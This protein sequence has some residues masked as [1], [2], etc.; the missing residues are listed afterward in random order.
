V[1]SAALSGVQTEAGPAYLTPASILWDVPT[2]YGDANNTV[3]RNFDGTYRGP[4]SVRGALQNSYN[5]PAVKTM[6][7]TGTEAFIQTAQAMGLRF[8]PEAEV[9]L[10]SA[11]GST[12]VRLYDMMEAYGTISNDGTLAPLYAIE[13]ITDGAGNVINWERTPPSRAI[14]EPT[15]FLL[16]NIMSDD[17]ARIPAFGANNR[18]AF[19]NFPGQVAAKTGTSNDGIDLWTMGFTDNVVVGVWLGHVDNN[20]TFNTSGYLTASPLWRTIMEN[21]LANTTAPTPWDTPANVVQTQFCATTGTQ[22]DPT[23][24]IPCNDVRTGF[25]TAGQLPPPANE[26]YI[27]DQSVYTWTGQAASSFC[28]NDVE[29]FRVLAP[30]DPTATAWLTGNQSGQQFVQSLG[31]QNAIVGNVESACDANTQLLSAGITGPQGGSVVTSPQVQIQG[32]ISS[33]PNFQ[34]YDIQVASANAPDQFQIVDGP[35]T[36]LPTGPTLGT[37]DAS[38]AADGAY[39]IRVGINSSAGAPFGYAYRTVEFTLDKPE[40][41]PTPTPP[42]IPTAPPIGGVPGGGTATDGTTPPTPTLIP[43]DSGGTTFGGQAGPTPTI[44]FSG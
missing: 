11:L 38:N 24:A 13:E 5:V 29:S 33:A 15:A 27:R 7:F 14:S 36:T 8:L 28:P 17:Q 34:S 41:T 6:N 19:N 25:F 10:T 12:D 31:L 37:W 22:V 26:G 20:P 4:V 39:I 1:Y 16:Q 9:N 21:V 30:D 23:G 43:F 35:Y 2:T 42:P 40:P 44:D 3:I 32:N 18:L